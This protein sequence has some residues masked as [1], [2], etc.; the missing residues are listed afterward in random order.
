R[1]QL[2]GFSA[3]CSASLPVGLVHAQ[4]EAQA[5]RRPQAIAVSFEDQQLS[6]G[7]LNARANRLA[8]RLIAR[9]VGPDDRVA[10]CVERGLDMLVGVLAILKAG[11]GYVPL[12]PVYPAERLAYMLQDS[13]P[14]AV[15]TQAA[16]QQSLPLLSAAQHPVM[17][18]DA[19]V[20]D[21][22]TDST[23]PVVPG[24]GAQHLAYVIYTSGST[25]QPKGVMVE[26]GHVTRLFTATHAQFGFDEH[27]VWTLFH[28]FAFDFSVWEIWGALLY[29][30]R[31]VVVPA[32]C[33]RMPLEFHDLLVQEGVTVLNQTPSAFRSLIV[34]Q[35]QRSTA[36]SLRVVVFGGEALELPMLVPWFERND[37]E[38][39]RLVNMY[40]IT[41]IT[42]HATYRRI[43]EADVRA[44]RGSPIGQAIA[45][46]QLYVL[47][48]AGEPVPIGVTGELYVGGGGVVRGY[49][50]RP[51][52]T[53]ARFLHNPFQAGTRLYRTGDLGRWLPDGSLEYLGRNDFQVK[54]RGFR[55]ELGEI[56]ARLAACHGVGEAVVIA[57][58][59]TPGDKRLVGY[60]VAQ[61]EHAPD[62]ASL[63]QQLQK[64][65]PEYMVPSAFVQL[66]ALPLTPN[67]KLDRA[68]LPPPDQAAVASQAYEA[69][70]GDVEQAI[71]AIWQELLGLER[72]G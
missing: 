10:I 66:A 31:L 17:L 20:E 2:L 68:A 69:P 55:I 3:A 4:F 53:A 11:A 54:I 56:E 33:T 5:A 22:A 7:A 13:A 9:G 42:V 63:R 50:N 32:L 21:G 24:L 15:L 43:T 64:S 47:D 72:V 67:G 36:H 18:L 71:A 27:D 40:G 57:R 70:V 23:N 65:L 49:L 41:E 29:G 37:G 38:R 39:T 14:A 60:L 45:D 34:A 6:Y 58:E 59:D 16:L 51:E 26:H 48:G 25:G 19:V 28:S 30:G 35:Q 52:L 46:L 44:P 62:A 12:D 1:Q 61:A 8:H